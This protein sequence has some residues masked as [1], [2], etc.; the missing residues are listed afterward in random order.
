MPAKATMSPGYRWRLGLIGVVCLVFAAW[1]AYD[2]LVAYPRH[3]E[4]V[5]ALRQ[6]RDEH[7][8]D[9]VWKSKWE[10]YG[11]THRIA[12]TDYENEK[13]QWSIIA[14]FIQMGITLPLGLLFGF[15]YMRSFGRWIAT[16]A[17]GFTTS[18]GQEAPFASIVQLNK[19]RWR[20]KGIAE[21]RYR[22]G[23]IERTLVLDDWKFDAPATLTMLK[24][25]EAILTPEQIVGDKPAAQPAA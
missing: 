23:Q 13:A 8:A 12:V 5:R 6:I 17:K 2:G 9:E 4:H 24:E 20:S 25:V 22:D 21:V 11:Q 14:Q 1:S 3:N 19:E 7:P 18:W 10:E 16:D 15:H